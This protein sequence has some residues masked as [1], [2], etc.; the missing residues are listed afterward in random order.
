VLGRVVL[1]GGEALEHA[2]RTPV[3]AEV[4]EVGG[5]RVV[6]PFGLLLGVEVVEVA[7]EL[8]EAVHG[9]QEPVEVA[10]VVLAELA[11][12][13]AVRLEELCDRGVFGLQADRCP[14]EAHLAQPGPVDGLAGDEGGAARGA[15]LL[16][17]GVG[18]HHALAG[19]PV[20]VRGSVPHDAVAVAAQVRDPDVVAPDHD[21]VR[22]AVRHAEAPFEG[23]VG[24]SPVVC[25]RSRITPGGVIRAHL[26]LSG[27]MRT[28]LGCATVGSR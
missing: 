16:G 3:L 21:D 17:V 26:I 18:E 6:G 9:R 5:R 8:V 11:R 7:V 13:V 20:D 23:V 22:I 14:G 12:G 25:G 28:L 10:E 4:R 15:V 24:D 19:E 27:V 2:T 1:V